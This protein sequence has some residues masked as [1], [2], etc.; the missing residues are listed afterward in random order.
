[1]NKIIISTD[2]NCDLPGDICEKYNIPVHPLLYCFD[3][4]IYGAENKMSTKT[5]YE[6]LRNGER[7]TTMAVNSEDA[8][9]Y[10]RE[11]IENGNAIIHISF[12]S[13]LSCT[14]QNAYIAAT[15]LLEEY[16]SAKITII[17]SL[18]AS[19]GQGLLVCK[20]I[21]YAN[22]GHN[23]EE[24]IDYIEHIKLNIAHHFT[25]DSLEHLHRGGRI[26]KSASIIGNIINIKPLLH[27]NDSGELVPIGKVRGRKTSIMKLAS[28]ATEAKTS[29]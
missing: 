26:S 3:S 14:Y 7:A 13:A 19:L 20:A 10:F 21:I 17:D 8:K 28:L 25:V 11:H 4:I 9:D 1:M 27:M 24:V 23:Y 29:V 12:S 18:C 22:E 6:R 16:P 15:E 2:S 5:F